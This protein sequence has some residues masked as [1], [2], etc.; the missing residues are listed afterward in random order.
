[1]ESTLDLPSILNKES[2]IREWM[3]DPRSAAV[4]GSLFEQIMA[5]NNELFDTDSDGG[6]G[7]DVMEMMADMTLVNI[8][9]FQQSSLPMPADQIVEGLLMQVHGTKA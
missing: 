7:M 5:N 4:L 1:M 8:L 9:V 6:I 2:T 3:A